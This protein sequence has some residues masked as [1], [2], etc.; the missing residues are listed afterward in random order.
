M[1]FFDYWWNF[2]DWP[3]KQMTCTW[4]I[5]TAKPGNR[6]EM[7][8]KKLCNV[9]FNSHH[10]FF[11]IDFSNICMFQK[12]INM[13]MTFFLYTYMPFYPLFKPIHRRSHIDVRIFWEQDTSQF[14]NRDHRIVFNADNQQIHTL[15]QR[16]R[17]IYC[18]LSTF[19]IKF[20]INAFF[21]VLTFKEE[22]G[23]KELDG[24][25]YP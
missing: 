15:H 9:T 7:L 20:K 8:L 25:H 17:N 18:D 24:M 19:H 12:I 21:C 4:T 2:F 5:A 22:S 1:R 10:T 14:S 13:P 3:E 23:K 16:N 11:V 6:T